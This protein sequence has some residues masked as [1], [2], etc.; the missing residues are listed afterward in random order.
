MKDN[1]II[2]LVE[3][4]PMIS[5]LYRT[6]LAAEQYVV[7]LAFNKT[8]AIH[9][10]ERHRPKIILLD[11]MIPIGP[12]ENLIEYDHPVGFDI[13]EWVHHHDA[14]AHTKVVIITN[15]DSEE[16]KRHAEELGAALYLVKS[17]IEPKEMVRRVDAL[18]RAA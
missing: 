8:S 9:L 13:L 2:L 5:E 3:D 11:L 6:V 4:E 18:A 12:G 17:S 14:L 10:I 15:L 16:H 7:V 1:D